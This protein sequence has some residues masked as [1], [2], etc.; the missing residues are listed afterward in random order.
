MLRESLRLT[1]TFGA[2]VIQE[3]KTPQ[4]FQR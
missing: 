3:A 4:L 2:L 1:R